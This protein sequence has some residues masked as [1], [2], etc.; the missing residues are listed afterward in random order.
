MTSILAGCFGKALQLS[1]A[2]DDP[3]TATWVLA[4]LAQQA[5]DLGHGRWAI[6]M[7]HAAIDAARSADAPP[8]AIAELLVRQARANAVTVHNA[9]AHDAHT[10]RQVTELLAQADAAFAKGTSDRD[11]AWS[12]EFGEAELAAEAGYCWRRVGEPQRAALYA[13]QA[14]RGFGTA[15]ARST[16]FNQIHAAEAY[17]DQGEL[18]HALAYARAAVP[19]AKTLTST[20]AIGHV[21]AFATQIH[22]HRTTRQVKEFNDYLT[23]ELAG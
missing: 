16:Q 22:P 4:T 8:R 19:A 3:M 15:Y 9:G 14:L 5:C 13:E 23:T 10:R 20:R 11:P 7:A 18:E 21:R 12:A 17:L 1:K 2:A 6:R